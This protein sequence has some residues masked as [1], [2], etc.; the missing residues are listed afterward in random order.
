MFEPFTNIPH[1][2]ASINQEL[3]ETVKMG[4]DSKKVIMAVG[5]ATFTGIALYLLYKKV[6]LY[7]TK[8]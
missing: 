6:S 2:Q 7:P 1:F 5:L 3:S 8:I 4:V